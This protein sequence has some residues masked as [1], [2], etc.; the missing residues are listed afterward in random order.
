MIWIKICGT[1][2][3]QDALA[4][5]EAGASALGFV[6]APSPR[7]ISPAAARAIVAQLPA[8]VE[9]IGVFVNE[10]P[11]RMRA[12]AE[13]VG[14]SGLQLH[15]DESAEVG[16]ALQAGANGR[17]LKLFKTLHMGRACNMPFAETRALGE[18][19]DALLLDSG[20]AQQPG[21][22]GRVFDWEDAARTAAMLRVTS[23]II[24]AGGLTPENVAEAVARF[25]PWGVDVVTGVEREPGHKD[26]EKVRKFVQAAREPIQN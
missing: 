5:A 16:R 12:I 14:L 18:F 17:R 19:Y 15:G 7:Q 10:Q 8:K 22:T 25:Q 3:L 11:E 13:Q 23:N 6:F 21:G 2:S 20:S 1:T 9:T 26:A 24:V 4:A